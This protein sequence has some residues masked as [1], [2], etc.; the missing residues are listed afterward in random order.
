MVST[1]TFDIRS[2]V[3]N[4]ISAFDNKEGELKTLHTRVTETCDQVNQ[5]VNKVEI[6]EN[7]NNEH[8][9]RYDAL[10][11]ENQKLRN[12][13]TS[14]QEDQHVYNKVSQIIALEKENN[15]L[16]VE[17]EFLSKR[18]TNLLASRRVSET[19]SSVPPDPVTTDAHHDVESHTCYD[20][21]RQQQDE[22]QVKGEGEVKG[23]SE[24][25]GEGEGKVESEGENDDEEHGDEEHGD[26]GHS[27]EEP[28]EEPDV[29]MYVKTIKGIDY[30]VSDDDQMIIYEI[31]QEDESVGRRLGQLQKVN[32]KTKVVWDE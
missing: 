29:E 15:R 26:E 21:Q 2:A 27:E 23:D 16:K 4:I 7:Q 31:N 20:D 3:H 22:H 10:Y 8:L 19:S 6:L 30:Y 18:V 13:I 11:Q 28:E 25:E 1:P 24:V 14:L 12:E 5:L 9:K 17:I 32:G